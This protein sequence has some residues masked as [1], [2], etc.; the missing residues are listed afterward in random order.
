MDSR[1]VGVKERIKTD[2]ELDEEC[3]YIYTGD[4]GLDGFDIVGIAMIT[5]DEDSPD[6]LALSFY[7]NCGP[8]ASA[9][10]AIAMQGLGLD[11]VIYE[12]VYPVVEGDDCR[13]LLFGDDADQRCYFDVYKE[14]VERARRYN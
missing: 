4:N 12:D 9:N 14:Y 6:K 5:V 11:F 13:E 10:I 2:F 7:S 3:F 1:L 8:V